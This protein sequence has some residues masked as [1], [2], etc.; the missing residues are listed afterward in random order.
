M[1]DKEV[2]DE[3]HTLRKP[4]EKL[5]EG[6]ITSDPKSLSPTPNASVEPPTTFLKVL[7]R[8]VQFSL[9]TGGT[10]IEFASV[11]LTT[12]WEI[13]ESVETE[14]G[15][16]AL[17]SVTMTSLG[18]FPMSERSL[19]RNTE[20]LESTR[21]EQ[22]L[23]TGYIRSGGGNELLHRVGPWTYLCAA[24]AEGQPENYSTL[25]A[26]I[27]KVTAANRSGGSRGVDFPGVSC[28]H[29]KDILIRGPVSPG[30][31]SGNSVDERE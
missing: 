1:R 20:G 6:T 26:F 17:Q 12:F 25:R 9:A 30:N 14:T 8:D 10:A 22:G 3:R 24:H 21:L 16:E 19:P 18:T 31:D 27:D 4:Y 15:F 11:T 28:V 13:C 29:F 2:H 5:T 23:N 7:L